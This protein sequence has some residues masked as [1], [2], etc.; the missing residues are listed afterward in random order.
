MVCEY[1]NPSPVEVNYWGH[2]EKL[3]KRN[4]AGEILDRYPDLQLVNYGF[5]WHR[6]SN[7]PQD[8]FNWFLMRKTD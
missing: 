8:D 5:I 6:D 1:Y 7:F 2:T 3:F 4:F